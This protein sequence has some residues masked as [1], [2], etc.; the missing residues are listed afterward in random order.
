MNELMMTN[1]TMTSIQFSEIV[2]KQHFHVMRSIRDEAQKLEASGIDT[3]SKFGLSERKDSSGRTVHFFTLTRKGVLQLAARYDAATR[4]K[5]I[6]IADRV[7]KQPTFPDSMVDALNS[8]I[9]NEHELLFM[10]DNPDSYRQYGASQTSMFEPSTDDW[11]K[12][13]NENISRIAEKIGGKDVEKF[14][15]EECFDRLERRFRCNLS[16]RVAN[17]KKNLLFQG[18]ALPLTRQI[19]KIDAITADKRLREAFHSVVKDMAHAIGVEAI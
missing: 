12:L 18:R 15:L 17:I 14:V 11:R 9:L 6:D 3:Q 8:I 19:G 4:A 13:I 10:L 5:L 7:E 2:G 1:T 16:I